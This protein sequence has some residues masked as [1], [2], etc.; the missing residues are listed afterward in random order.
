MLERLIHEPL[1]R[2]IGQPL[3]TL[4]SLNKIDLIWFDL[5]T[6]TV[7]IEDVIVECDSLFEPKSFDVEREESIVAVVLR[8]IDSGKADSRFCLFWFFFFSLSLFPSMPL[9]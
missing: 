7:E 4:S 8:M 1:A 2:E 3:L 6:F 9:P 5:Y